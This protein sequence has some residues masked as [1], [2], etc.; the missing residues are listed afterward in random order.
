[1]VIGMSVKA[2]FPNNDSV[3][4]YIDRHIRNSAVNAFQNNRLNTA[5]KGI[6]NAVDSVDAKVMGGVRVVD[7]V[8]KPNDTTLAY[9]IKGQEY[10][11]NVGSGVG[12]GVDSVLLVGAGRFLDSLSAIR[13]IIDDSTAINK[14]VTIQ[15]SST[16]SN[17][18]TV[19]QFV[20]KALSEFR[21]LTSVDT[22]TV[23]KLNVNRLP[24]EFRYDP[25]DNT[26]VDDSVM[27]IVTTGG[28]RLKRVYNEVWVEWFGAIPND[29]IDDSYAWQKAINFVISKAHG[30]KLRASGGTFNVKNLVIAK[31]IG[32]EAQFV[33]IDIE[34]AAPALENISVNGQVTELYTTDNQAFTMAVQLGRM[35]HIKNILFNGVAPAPPNEKTTV[36]WTTSNWTGS[37]TVRNNRYSPHAGFLVDP[38]HVNVSS[39]GDRYPGATAWY[40]N[41]ATGGTS[42]VTIEGCSFKN[43]IAG[44]AI[45]LSGSTSNCDNIVFKHGSQVRNKNFWVTCQTQSR[46]NSI[47]DLYSFGQTQ[48]LINCTEYGA[49]QGT[50]P[51]IYNS[52][53]AGMHK[54]LYQIQGEFGGFSIS[55]THI[56]LIHSFGRLDGDQ[57]VDIIGCKVDLAKPGLY[58]TFASPVIAEG[59]TLNFIGGSLNWFDNTYAA[60]FPFNVKALNF[61]GTS[62]TG[63]IPYNSGALNS[64]SF[65]GVRYR[66][67]EGGMWKLYEANKIDDVSLDDIQN[68]AIIP[69]TKYTSTLYDIQYEAVG[70]KF[71]RI[72]LDDSITL[73]ID[74]TTY[75]ATFTADNGDMYKAGDMLT[76][77]SVEWA[78]DIYTYSSSTL[79]WVSNVSGNT[80]T[81]SYVPYGADETT[82]YSTYLTR[83]P[84]FIGRT[85]GNV[86]ASST[87][88]T[89]AVYFNSNQTFVVGS[90]IKGNGIQ[91]GTRV[92]AIS[93]S[94]ITISLPATITGTNVMLYDAEIKATATNK[95]IEWWTPTTVQSIFDYNNTAWFPG[96]VITNVIGSYPA[97]WECITPGLM[98][99][100]TPPVFYDGTVDRYNPY[101]TGAFTASGSDGA[102]ITYYGGLQDASVAGDML[103][104]YGSYERTIAGRKLS[105]RN[106]STASAPSALE[107]DA[108][109]VIKVP[110]VA[111]T[112]TVTLKANAAGEILRAGIDTADIASFAAKVRSLFSAGSNITITNGVISATGVGGSGLT[113]VEVTGTSQTGATNTKYICQNAGLTTISLPTTCSMGDEI[114]I[115]SNGGTLKISQ[116]G[117]QQIKFTGGVTTM[118]A[119]G[120]LTMTD[121]YSA[122]TLICV[123]GS[124]ESDGEWVV[125]SNQGTLNGL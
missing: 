59:G 52:N 81:L 109:G 63:G 120:Y 98:G 12:G 88:I 37:G 89:G 73:N 25:D 56:E 39:G 36:E 61:N 76:T 97:K 14:D 107:I 43:Y 1:M 85:T 96:D 24:G 67:Y 87:S 44:I 34:G 10:Q 80:V 102:G 13:E 33:T 11:L 68:A 19:K 55:G 54:Y 91:A 83:I 112:G 115:V 28:K 47:T 31:Y 69:G 20:G 101:S 116:T 71:D 113:T 125:K 22:G 111:G 108:A 16:L 60:A 106:L 2:Q 9:R 29:G 18:L 41:T 53:I 79:G 40:T 49:Q 99:S 32:G 86:T 7:S 21:A 122:V 23:Y 45:A 118:G 15:G 100:A 64:T 93:G 4:S 78:D 75:T 70:N 92:T 117:T 121:E 17:P 65:T 38:F 90:H 48:T 103:I 30:A 58:G 51:H 50:P 66:G 119:T 46:G 42:G 62:I 77:N 105:I 123:V 94:T 114:V 110:N 6:I 27:I 74:S 5:L 104:D 26:S 72:L 84:R 95:D 35:V 124:G 8:W 57:T 3:R 82:Y